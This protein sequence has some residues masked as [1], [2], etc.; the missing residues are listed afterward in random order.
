M[1]LPDNEW[2]K[3]KCGLKGLTY[4]A[5]EIPSVFSPVGV[6]NEIIENGINGFLAGSNDEWVEVLSKLI[7]SPELRE[8]AG[9]AGRKTVVEKYSVE[10]NKSKYL[11]CFEA[12]INKKCS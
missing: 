5:C 3:G 4:M 9:K 12:V 1:P 10:A 8:R 7:E 11:E 6:N 2:T